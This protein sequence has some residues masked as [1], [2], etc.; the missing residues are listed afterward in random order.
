M[1]KRNYNKISTEAA[2]ANVESEKVEETLTDEVIDGSGLTASE[3]SGEIKMTNPAAD[4]VK[5]TYGIVDNCA[6]LNVRTKPNIKSDVV[7]VIPAGLKV[8]IV[9]DSRR[10]FYEVYEV[11]SEPSQIPFRGFCMRKYITLK[12]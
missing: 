7:C 3:V 12:K 2:K 11:V 5:V 10:D 1:S 4:T 6:R 8:K 9:D